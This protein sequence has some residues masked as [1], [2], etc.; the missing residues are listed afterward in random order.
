MGAHGIN[1]PHLGAGAGFGVV[2]AGFGAVGFGAA[3]FGGS[4]GTSLEIG[5]ESDFG[6]AVAGAATGGVTTAAC[7]SAGAAAGSAVADTAVATGSAA[8]SFIGSGALGAGGA[9]TL[10]TAVSTAPPST[11]EP[12]LASP[13]LG[14]TNKRTPVTTTALAAPT[15]IIKR[16]PAFRS[17][18]RGADD[19]AAANRAAPDPD[20]DGTCTTAAA[21]VVIEGSPGRECDAGACAGGGNGASTT[22]IF[23]PVGAREG[24]SGTIFIVPA[25][26]TGA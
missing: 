13:P 21:P 2:V 25:K 22:G 11:D 5:L 16:F 7:V 14:I 20:A 8:A 15:M 19:E 6:A 9:G 4:R 18:A 1:F 23:P 12:A 17:S 24:T 26:P 10:G 3:V